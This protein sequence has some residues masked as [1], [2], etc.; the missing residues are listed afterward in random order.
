MNA[1]YSVNV[2]LDDD[3][4]YVASVEDLPG[5]FASGFTVEELD[6]SLSEAISQYLSVPGVVA[7]EFCSI[8]GQ[9][10]E[11][12]GRLDLTADGRFAL[13]LVSAG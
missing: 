8:P 10:A 3:G 6:E 5:C 9:L 7:V 1:T 13:E 11:A 4:S 2:E 12:M